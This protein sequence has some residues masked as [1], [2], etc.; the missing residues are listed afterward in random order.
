MGLRG[1]DRSV[2]WHLIALTLAVLVPALVFAAIGLVRTANEQ[3]ALV[4]QGLVSTSHALALAVDREV[5]RSIA[6][7][8][9]LA[10]SRS[11]DAE[12]LATFR[13]EALRA[14]DSQ[15]GWW[16]ISLV[17]A[18]GTVV[19]RLMERPEAA[20]NV[21]DLPYVRAVLDT[22]R[23]AVSGLYAARS[24]GRL[25]VA[26]A[27][28]VLREGEVRHILIAGIEPAVF[29][30]LLGMPT[31]REWVRA[32]VDGEGVIVARNRAAAQFVGQPATEAFLQTTRG[33]EERPFEST[34]IDGQAVRGAF[35]RAPLSGW[36]AVVNV[37][38]EVLERPFHRSLLRLLA[39][40][41]ILLVTALTGAV[42]FGRRLARPLN[43]LA[44]VA[45][46]I[47]RGEEVATPPTG[48]SELVVLGGALGEAAASIRA[49]REENLRL[50]S[51][52]QR[53]RSQAE[54]QAEMLRRLQVIGDDAGLLGL[55]P[56]ALLDELMR[57]VCEVL[58]ADSAAVLLLDEART[59]LRTAGFAGPGGGAAGRTVPAGEGIAGRIVR[60]GEGVV[61]A[62]VTAADG[63]WVGRRARSLAGVPLRIESE[64]AGVMYVTAPQSGRFTPDLELLGHVADRV[65][66]ALQRARVAERE[67]QALEAQA[68]A[69]AK[70]DFIAVLSHELRTPL[71]AIIG[72]VRMLRSG[73]IDPDRAQR[74]LAGIE[75]SAVMQGQLVDDLLDL[76]RILAGK[77][78][79]D[80]QPVD[81]P[82]LVERTVET[83][84]MEAEA[85]GLG[86]ATAIDP[87]VPVVL[88]DGRRLQQVLTNLLTNAIKFTERGGR[89]EVSLGHVGDAARLRVADTGQGI[90]PALLPFVFDR[91]WQ[92]DTDAQRRHGGL[93]L[94][95]SIVR[96][97]VALHGG[98]VTAESPGRGRGATFTVTLPLA[99]AEL[100][101][102]APS[103]ATLAPPP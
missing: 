41:L 11:L 61:V 56:R 53:A 100:P 3:V 9:L 37:R 44:R 80:R 6:A 20:R 38:R 25:T 92:G 51:A 30:P 94:G 99:G 27:V 4:D 89:V 93:G 31:E 83:V 60:E 66:L 16:T 90:E 21:A 22:R 36:F 67:R 12:G 13:Q 84:R 10:T 46:A 78:E 62:E 18:D 77:M 75:R 14:R 55:G 15:E 54:T 102:A 86:L 63:G 73:R 76:S 7:L 33:T 97:L 17:R 57:R 87:T 50:L 39:L 1:R 79:I 95:L 23:P 70:E 69:R 49:R 71:T 8:Q 2:Q 96:H 82:G 34:T 45:P 103:P 5:A 68:A 101:A 85:K 91:L 74:A 59:G 52:E 35:T 48:V 65:V 29:S 43:A 42:I 19:L 88:G 64:V 81:L 24:T 28:P 58:G 72:W 47:A 40:G 26:V 98:T 32:I